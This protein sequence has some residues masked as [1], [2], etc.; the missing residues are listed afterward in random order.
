MKKLKDIVICHNQKKRVEVIIGKESVW[1]T[2]VQIAELFDV[3]KSAIS[4]HVKNIYESGELSRS[5]TVSKRQ[6]KCNLTT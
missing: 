5:S 1:L 3:K 2:Q 6:N 4:K